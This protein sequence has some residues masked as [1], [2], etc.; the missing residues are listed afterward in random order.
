MKIVGELGEAGQGRAVWR[1][2]IR[3]ASSETRIIA[4]KPASPNPDTGAHRQP[5]KTLSDDGTHR[6]VVF[7]LAFNLANVMCVWIPN[8][9][10]VLDGIAGSVRLLCHGPPGPPLCGMCPQTR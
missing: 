5:R 6:D 2:E 3:K 1:L 8:F 7:C 10:R 9:V 4:Q